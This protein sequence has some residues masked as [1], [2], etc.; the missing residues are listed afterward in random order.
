LQDSKSNIVQRGGEKGIREK[1][2][3]KN[4]GKR[5]VGYDIRRSSL[6]KKEVKEWRIA[7]GPRD[8]RCWRM[9]C[10]MP[11]AQTYPRA[12]ESTSKGNQ[13]WEICR[14]RRPVSCGTD[15]VVRCSGG[16]KGTEPK[17]RKCAG[18]RK[19]LTLRCHPFGVP[20][21]AALGKRHERRGTKTRPEAWR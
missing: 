10:K 15:L 7:E 14:S 18:G 2:R 20:S 5:K 17:K 19:S 9:G 3:R 8:S 6:T 12:D 4:G 13:D 11:L 21:P 1:K 16:V